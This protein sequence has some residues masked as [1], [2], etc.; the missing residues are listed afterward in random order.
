M[1]PR[2]GMAAV[3]I[4]IRGLAHT[5]SSPA[6]GSFIV[7]SGGD[8]TRPGR[9]TVLR[10]SADLDTSTTSGRDTSPGPEWLL[11]SP[12]MRIASAEAALEP[13]EAV[14]VEEWFAAVVWAAS[15]EADS[16]G[17]AA[18]EDSTAAEVG[19]ANRSGL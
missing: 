10:S 17:P 11:A 5:R 2:C 8:S 14:S 7:R 12:D 1:L 15:P 6:T 16:M 19:A 18:E 3:G 13:M 4:G 9:S